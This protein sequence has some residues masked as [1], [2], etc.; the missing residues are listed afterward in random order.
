MLVDDDLRL[1]SGQER[2]N[3]AVYYDNNLVERKGAYSYPV[4]GCVLSGKKRREYADKII[5]GYD[6]FIYAAGESKEGGGF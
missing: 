1:P 4:N 6:H 3:Y 5:N 2:F